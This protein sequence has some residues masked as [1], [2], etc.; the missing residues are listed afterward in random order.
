LKIS[1]RDHKLSG[2]VTADFKNREIKK[3]VYIIPTDRDLVQLLKEQLQNL[4]L[5][6]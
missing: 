6:K 1:A 3:G 4:I 2:E 5:G